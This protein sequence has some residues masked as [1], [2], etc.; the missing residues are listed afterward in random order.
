MDVCGSHEAAQHQIIDDESSKTCLLLQK[1]TTGGRK[2]MERKDGR[3]F[4]LRSGAAKN[5]KEPFQ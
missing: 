2:E 4:K 5:P 3:V 1:T